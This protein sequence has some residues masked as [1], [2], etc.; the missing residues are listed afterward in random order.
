MARKRPHKGNNRRGSTKGPRKQHRTITGTLRVLRPGSAVV[1][2][3]EGTFEVTRSGIREAMSGDEVSVF[4]V[5]PKGGRG[6][7]GRSGAHGNGRGAAGGEKRAVVDSVV[8]R[9]NHTLLGRFELAGPLGAV[10]P[11]D[12]RL[13]HDFFVVP[14]DKSPERLGVAPGD[15]V[16]ARIVEYPTPY[17]AA[18]VTIDRRV[19]SASELDMDIESVIASH[20]LACEFSPATLAQ[21]EGVS[22][23]VGDVLAADP[24]RADLRDVMCVTIDPADARDFDDAVGARKRADG[25]FDLD[26]H[27]ADV[28]HYLPWGSSMDLEARSRT[29]SVYL[30]DRVIPMLPERLSNDVCSLR[31]GEDRLAMTVRMR[32]D[33]QGAVVS[34]K[35]CA[36]AIRSN[37][38][39]C[40]DEVDELLSGAIAPA[41]LP[42]VDASEAD[43]VA[44]MLRV[45]DRIRDLRE[46][47]RRARGAIDFET[48]EAKVVLDDEGHPTGVSV[49]NR[50][51]ATGLVEE[52]ML[53]ANESVARILADSEV[54][55]AYRVHEQPSAEDLRHTVAPLDELGLLGPGDAAALMAGEP[56]AIQRVLDAARGTR[57]EYLAS[58]LLLRAQRRAVYLPQNLGHYA[59][60]ATA[61]CHFTSPIRRYPDDIVHRAL[62]A[63]LAGKD[64]CPEQRAVERMLPQLCS[65]CSR[66]ERTA[67]AAA[68]DSQKVK[69]AE[70]YA[71]RIGAREAGVVSG[72]ERFGVFVSLDET[73]ADGLIPVRDLGSEWFEFDEKR[74]TLTGE[75]TGTVWGLGRRV[76]VEVAGVDVPRGRIDF[77]LPPAGKKDE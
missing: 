74:M 12:N 36:A 47:A 66:M 59:L 29:C 41:D 17:T 77:R 11:L 44:E 30:V 35:A 13:C 9:A 7:G 23:G 19:G 33:A 38:R 20:G 49:R 58:A 22:A 3:P 64:G 10:V 24:H 42:C 61:Y 72:C 8:T 43:A 57:G 62:K 60:G 18:V 52:A 40:Y 1:E 37:A 6:G 39:L 63:H 14:E 5:G 51:R 27:I 55:A 34:A 50:T 26:V 15:V 73:C 75:S 71:G 2:T 67:D 32:L 69:M 48:R 46:R 70:L 16:V 56:S 28:T 25:G 45:L 53:L 65:D 21:A 54:P 31:P 76:V 4:L 68:R